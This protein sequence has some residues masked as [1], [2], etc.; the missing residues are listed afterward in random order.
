MM[1]RR[2]KSIAWQ[3]V[4]DRYSHNNLVAA[5]TRSAAD[6]RSYRFARPLNRETA[7][8]L[9]SEI[10]LVAAA[11]HAVKAA[12][13]TRAAMLGSA[14]PRRPAGLM[15]AKFD[16]VVDFLLAEVIVRC[17]H[18]AF[19]FE[20]SGPTQCGTYQFRPCSRLAGQP[21]WLA[22][23]PCRSGGEAI[24]VPQRKKNSPRSVNTL[25][26]G[27][28]TRVAIEDASRFL[29]ARFTVF[30]DA[31]AGDGCIPLEKQDFRS[32]HRFEAFH[33]VGERR[34]KAK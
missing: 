1:I 17:V 26:G 16:L 21:T 10:P 11:M 6:R 9:N 12:R 27:T 13:T 8:M 25:H 22:R 29:S 3:S 18:G 20:K 23:S 34:V 14:R 2:P 28:S 7:D 30:V 19:P 4:A 32:F 33:Q 15:S 5:N 31:A 24:A